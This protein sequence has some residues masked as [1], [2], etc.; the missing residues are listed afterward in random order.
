MSMFDDVGNFHRKF[1]L[2]VTQ[3]TR[4]AALLSEEL[5]EYRRRFLEEEL[6]EMASAHDAGDLT[7]FADALADLVWVALGTC[8]FAG[9][10]FDEVW[11]H[12]R[13]ANMNKITAPPDAGAHKRD[14]ANYRETIRKP[15]GWVSPEVGIARSLTSWNSEPEQPR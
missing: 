14:A 6:E 10:P 12:V 13:Y 9:I 8:H 1:G 4:K 5:F 11:P 2:P 15:A 3:A 7:G